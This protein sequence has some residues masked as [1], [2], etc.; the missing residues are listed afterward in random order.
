MIGIYKIQSKINNKYYIGSSINIT[1]RWKEHKYELINNRHSNSHLQNFVNKYGL[2]NLEFI[3]LEECSDKDL[4]IKE[5][6]YLDKLENSFNICI[7]AKAPMYNR[8][9]SE[10]TLKKMSA[11]QSKE[12]NP[13]FGTKRP[14]YVI[15]AMIE[16]RRAKGRTI[17]EKLKR[18]V[19]LPNRK[20]VTISKNDSK[21]RC[22]SL[23]HAAKI[24]GVKTQSIASA[25]KRNSKSKGW[26]ITTHKDIVYCH[27]DKKLIEL[28][29][30]LKNEA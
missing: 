17:E 4:I 13:M 27:P 7:S 2:D 11:S 6:N 30:N 20:E 16:G 28:L 14:Q 25:I 10:D 3:V 12:N 29:E 15:N 5:Q 22:F 18:L 19:N 24:I 9:H 21:I 8:N 26:K 1:K 23:A